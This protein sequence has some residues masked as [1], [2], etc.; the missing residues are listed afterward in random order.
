[1]SLL[2]RTAILVNTA[3]GEILDEKFLIKMLKNRKIF[4]AGFDVY[5]NEPNLNKSLYNL[6]NVILLPH[7][8]SATFETRNKMAELAAKNVINVLNGKKALTPV[9]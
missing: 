6:K 3:R 2:K 1:L 9:R 7:I 5:E 8:G 4:S